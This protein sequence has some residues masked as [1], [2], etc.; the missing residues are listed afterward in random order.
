MYGVCVCVCVCVV[1]LC[2]CVCVCV[3]GAAKGWCTTCLGVF[4]RAKIDFFQIEF[5]VFDIVTTHNNQIPHTQFASLA[6]LDGG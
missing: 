5:F 1:C 4:D 2:V 6:T 3:R